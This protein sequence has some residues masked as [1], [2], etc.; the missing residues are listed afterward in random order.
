MQLQQKFFTAIIL[1]CSA[2]SFAQT[3]SL[4]F[5]D[6]FFFLPEKKYTTEDINV[7][8]TKVYS[9]NTLAD[10]TKEEA[11]LQFVV[12]TG[13]ISKKDNIFP[14]SI[15]YLVVFHKVC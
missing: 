2:F 12:T 14:I 11:V 4:D 7:T 3:N 15:K 13:K 10:S 6:G 8:I 5:K 1:L 9:G